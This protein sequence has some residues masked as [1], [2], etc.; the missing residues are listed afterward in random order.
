MV[1]VIS[2][3]FQ[4]KALPCLLLKGIEQVENYFILYQ[5][6]QMIEIFYP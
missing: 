6:H 5:G 2:D 1:S 4:G 3:F